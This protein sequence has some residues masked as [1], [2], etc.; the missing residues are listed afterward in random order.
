MATKL[1]VTGGAGFIGSNFVHHVLQTRPSTTIVNL[2]K[3]T[4]AGNLRNLDGLDKTYPNRHKF[5]KGDICDTGLVN[6]LVSECDA[7]IHFAAE[8][9][10]DRSILDAS[11][12]IQTNVH[13]TYTLLN[14][15]LAAGGRRFVHVSTDEVYGSL[16]DTD[17]AFTEET[18]IQTNS[19]YSASK[20]A[21]DLFVRAFVHTHGLDAMVTRCSNN[22]GPYQFPEK[23]IPLMITNAIENKQ[24]PVYGSGKNVRDW[25][26]VTDHCEG[27]MRVF[28][29]GKK[30]EVYNFGGLSE[31]RNLD[32][33]HTILKGLGKDESLIKYVEDRKGHDWRYAIDCAKVAK[34]LNWKPSV[35]FEKG[36]QK[37][38]EWYV[39][40]RKW[41]EEV[42][43]G[44]YRD[45]YEM[46]YG[47]RS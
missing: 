10:V 45:F 35:T 46:N 7:V 21:S 2:D 1:L 16:S 39:E 26:Y 9:H 44:A 18:P 12:F 25:I 13:G 20:A 19:P 30:G 17:P 23:L 40:N 42:K 33:V 6:K 8:S 27:V 41:W 5:V 22:Y 34:E 3:L 31:R 32:V 4:Y 29:N 36:I 47:G 28:E 38:I 43:S 15:A 24:L 14:A 11:A 37:T